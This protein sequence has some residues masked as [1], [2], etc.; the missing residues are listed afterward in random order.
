MKFLEVGNGNSR[1]KIA[2]RNRSGDPDQTG[3]LWLGGFKS[4]M[5]GIKVNTLDQWAEHANRGLLRFDYSGHG[6]SEGEF[7]NATVSDWIE[8]AAVVFKR[9]A[10][11]NRIIIGS[12]M[13]AWIAL[14]LVKRF[15]DNAPEALERIAGIIMIA[16][17]WNMTQT[18]MEQRFTED[19]R[20]TI[21]SQGVYYRP[22]AYDDGPYP[23]T[24]RL[25]EDGRKHNINDA[26]L[27][28]HCPVRILHGMRDPDVPWQ[29]SMDL[30]G[31]LKG[32]ITLTLIGDA[33]HRLSR[34]QDIA[35]LIAEIEL[36]G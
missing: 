10:Q 27:D 12:S 16:P 24:A 2:Y 5:N 36:L 15:R 3:L 18:L 25:I 13:G 14:L 29:H 22:S 35:R 19:I 21:E 34:D 30:V 9:I 28:I 7:E 4:D 8:E 23:I 32:D 31:L 11:G 17:A 33:N 20:Q 26:S 1:R 6:T